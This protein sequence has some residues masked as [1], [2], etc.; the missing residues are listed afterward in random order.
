MFDR[1]LDISPTPAFKAPFSFIVDRSVEML[2]FW[3]SK[4][5]ALEPALVQ[6]ALETLHRLRY[7]EEVLVGWDMEES[8]QDSA[9][10]S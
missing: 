4:F 2:S 9:N 7:Y 8:V 6:Q 10:I 3:V 5:G 1:N